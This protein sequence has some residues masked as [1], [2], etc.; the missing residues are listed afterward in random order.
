M[1]ETSAEKGAPGGN[2]MWRNARL[3]LDAKNGSPSILTYTH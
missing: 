3:S 1:K 2:L